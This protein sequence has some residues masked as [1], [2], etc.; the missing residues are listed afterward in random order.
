MW[1]ILTLIAV[2][3]AVFIYNR[4]VQLKATSAA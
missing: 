4:V 3:V 1:P 2:V